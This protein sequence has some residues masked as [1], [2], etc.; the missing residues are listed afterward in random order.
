MAFAMVVAACSGTTGGA[1]DNVVPTTDSS[2][3]AVGEATASSTTAGAE[4]SDG[5]PPDDQGLPPGFP[6]GGVGT[7]VI[8][9]QTFDSP[10]VGNCEID[11]L[12]NPSPDDLDLS[13]SL[14]SFGGIDA[15]FLEVSYREAAPG[16][17]EGNYIYT[18]FRPELQMQDDSGNYALFASSGS[19]VTGPDGAWYLDEN[20]NLPAAIAFDIPTHNEVPSIEPPVVTDGDRISGMVSL[21]GDSGSVDVSFDLTFITDPIDCSL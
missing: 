1:V 5:A 17:A 20:E 14:G 21:E 8:D 6:P 3:S 19:Y 18:Q 9:G 13:A 2:D 10:W 12:F 15:F 4:P 16:A 7:V 11:E